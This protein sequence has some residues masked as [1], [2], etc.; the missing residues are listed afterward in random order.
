MTATD[1]DQK[2]MLPQVIPVFPL[3]GAL[4]LPR[5]RLPLNIFEPHYLAMVRDALDADAVIGMVQPKDAPEDDPT[6]APAIFDIGCLGRISECTETGDDRLL[7]SLFGICRFRIEREIEVDTP[8]RQVVAQ[9][10][11]FTSDLAAVGP[12]V[13]ALEHAAWTRTA[14]SIAPWFT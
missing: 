3:S 1:Q 14:T 4:L 9:Y 11:E 2:S 12:A 13:D 10:G 5:S 8:Y 7:I 6:T